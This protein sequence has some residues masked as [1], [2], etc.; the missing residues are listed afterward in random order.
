MAQ[1]RFFVVCWFL[2]SVPVFAAGAQDKSIPIVLDTLNDNIVGNVTGPISGNMTLEGQIRGGLYNFTNT[3][4]DTLDVGNGNF[5][6][7]AHDSA[8]HVTVGNGYDMQVTGS[9]HFVGPLVHDLLLTGSLYP[10]GSILPKTETYSLDGR[11]GET[12]FGNGTTAKTLLGG[13]RPAHKIDSV[14]TAASPYSVSWSPDCTYLAVA[15]FIGDTLEVYSFSGG[16]LTLLDRILVGTGVQP[17]SVAWSPDGQRVALA[18]RATS[19][20]QIYSFINGSLIFEGSVATGQRPAF[21]AWSPDSQ[22]LALSTIAGKSLEVYVVAGGDPVPTAQIT[23]GQHPFC[24]SWSPTGQYI[25]VVDWENCFVEVF[26]FAQRKLSLVG[27][28]AT[29]I[30]PLGVSWSP[31]GEYIAVVNGESGTLQIF[32]FTSSTI[33]CIMAVD[34]GILP[35]SVSWSPDGRVLALVCTNTNSLQFYSFTP[36]DVHG[37]LVF[38][39]E[40][41][42]G[43]YSNPCAV[44]WSPNGQYVA[45]GNW[46]SDTMRVYSIDPALWLPV[47]SVAGNVRCQ[48]D[49]A[50]TGS[51]CL[52]VANIEGSLIVNSSLVK[53][54]APGFAGLADTSDFGAGV[55]GDGLPGG[56]G[57]LTIGGDG[58]YGGVGGTGTLLIGGGVGG[59]G[60]YSNGL[61]ALGGR[62][63]VAAK[64]PS[65][66]SSVDQLTYRLELSPTWTTS[67]LI[68]CNAQVTGGSG[69]AETAHCY[70]ANF[71]LAL[72]STT[73][74]D[75]R[76]NS[77]TSYGYKTSPE[78][79]ETEALPGAPVCLLEEN[80]LTIVLQ[81]PHD[82]APPY[83]TSLQVTG[84]VMKIW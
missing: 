49:F 5:V 63:L 70:H 52:G 44:A 41:K 79:L 45:E 13:N 65:S 58:S 75:S 27:T 54:G 80:S 82:A 60:N 19:T 9:V 76:V 26:S 15:N 12:R 1:L 28:C 64:N 66:F 11:S 48:S 4:L 34:T 73:S 61:L 3:N 53:M 74:V 14:T 71:A 78:A 55:G 33:T 25:A 29:G 72:L 24:I 51:S 69:S 77:A 38:L 30:N 10:Y 50:L 2:W 57:K 36:S 22:F 37:M 32:S 42:T 8:T 68:V 17:S 31:N 20:L 40:A 35:Y 81:A 6:V 47:L 59:S 23:A 43:D 7:P 21:I 18:I 84:P 62:Y 83:A 39:G 67:P 46:S 56:A 16:S